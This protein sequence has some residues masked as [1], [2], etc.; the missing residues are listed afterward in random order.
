MKLNIKLKLAL[1]FLFVF[2][3]SATTVGIA[4]GKLIRANEQ[5]EA[6]GDVTLP[7]VLAI[8]D[9]VSTNLMLRQTTAEVLIGLPNAPEN[10]FQRLEQ[11]L[12]GHFA[13]IER[14]TET[15]RATAGPEMLV[16][17][18]D[19][20][21]IVAQITEATNR[22]IATEMAGD[23]DKANSLFHGELNQLGESA[24][25]KLGEMR[26]L[27]RSQVSAEMAMTAGDLKSARVELIILLAA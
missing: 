2:A 5:Y 8:E 26:N 7:K 15:I 18:G 11:E 13:D 27:I 25:S 12:T 20:Q 9:V 22:T 3:L 23:G 10:H 1:T 24:T 14:N 4:I 17:L 21:E 16:L 6:L 19:L